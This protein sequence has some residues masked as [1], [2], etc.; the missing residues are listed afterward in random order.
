VAILSHGQVIEALVAYRLT[1]PAPLLRV[2]DWAAEWAVPKVFGIDAAT[3]NDDR[4]G[5]ALS[6]CRM[7][8][9]PPWS[10]LT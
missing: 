1:S 2:E 8:T 3:L 7:R 4:I 5:R 10:P 6:W 9:W